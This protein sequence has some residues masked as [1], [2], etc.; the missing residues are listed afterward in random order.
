MFI[1]DKIKSFR[2]ST[3]LFFWSDELKNNCWVIVI[4]TCESETLR[5]TLGNLGLTLGLIAHNF[6]HFGQDHQR[7]NV[8][9][10]EGNLRRVKVSVLFQTQSLRWWSAFCPA[11]NVYFLFSQ[12]VVTLQKDCVVQH[13]GMCWTLC[14]GGA[15][16]S[17]SP[18]VEGNLRDI[19]SWST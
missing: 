10:Y 16:L 7:R 11:Q 19:T 12:T 1:S 18:M 5:L 6:G 14:N 17:A 4:C 3:S 15:N 9:V 13:W 2:N 8:Y